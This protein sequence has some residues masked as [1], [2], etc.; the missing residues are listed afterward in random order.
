MTHYLLME[1]FQGL[2][3]DTILL[4]V[5]NY[6]DPIPFA[7]QEEI[8]KEGGAK[9]MWFESYLKERSEIFKEVTQ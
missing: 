8:N 9:N 7:T 6:S 1:N 3:K 4:P 5:P 2:I